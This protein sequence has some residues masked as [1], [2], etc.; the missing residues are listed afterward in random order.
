MRWQ[1]AC[2]PVDM[3]IRGYSGSEFK[4]GRSRAFRSHRLC[5][6][7]YTRFWSG[8]S[9]SIIWLLWLTLPQCN[10]AGIV[11][12]VRLCIPLSKHWCVWR[13]AF[14]CHTTT[15][16]PLLLSNGLFPDPSV[17]HILVPIFSPVDSILSARCVSCP[18]PPLPL[19][20]LSLLSSPG[21]LVPAPDF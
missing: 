14:M 1:R 4:T 18:L 13:G 21:V 9:E 5:V 10:L 16:E 8:S 19:L 20:I 11:D 6:F 15:L 2:V 7:V 12:G 3:L 17:S